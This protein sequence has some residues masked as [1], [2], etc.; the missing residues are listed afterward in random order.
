M[1]VNQLIEIL[2][3]QY[4][5]Q[6]E[7]MKN[8]TSF[9]IG[10]VADYLVVPQTITQLKALLT[11]IN[12]TNTPF[13]VMGNGSN[14]L[15]AESGIRGIVIKT[16][17]INHLK[18][19]GAKITAGA[20]VL[21]SKLANEALKKSLSGLEFSHGIPGTFGGG[22]VMNAGAYGGELK[23]VIIETQYLDE[24]NEIKTLTNHKY[25]YRH[26]IFTDN[27][28]W[29][30]L[31]STALLKLDDPKNIKAKMDEFALQRKTKQPLELPSAGSVFKRPEGYFAGKLIDDC[32]LRGFSI[33]DAQ[34]SPKHCGFIVNNKNATAD[35]VMNLI[36]QIQNKVKNKYGIK[37]TT[38]IKYVGGR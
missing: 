3:M 19:D 26:S 20:G 23:D 13:F 21:L 11:L 29:I 8:H 36:K 34:V 31:E 7:P 12:A 35:D 24:H 30:V 6:N 25:S 37:L 14:L 27:P 4:I 2:P 16:T 28:K 22:V 18:I 15:V 17:A 33:G 5:K 9:K 38:E 10:G 1:N 32:G